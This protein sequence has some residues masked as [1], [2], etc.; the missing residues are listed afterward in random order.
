MCLLAFPFFPSRS[1]K[2]LYACYCSSAKQHIASLDVLLGMSI[3]RWLGSS[4]GLIS[5]LHSA[6][7][8]YGAICR[9]D[10]L[11]ERRLSAC[12]HLS[13]QGTLYYFKFHIQETSSQT[14]T[15]L[16]EAPLYYRIYLAPMYVANI[17]LSA[18]KLDFRG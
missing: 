14:K 11:V 6:R 12:L 5:T 8:Q 1:I 10:S 9:F 16:G 13:W 2:F 7:G 15:C 3:M 18:P 17:T 4:K